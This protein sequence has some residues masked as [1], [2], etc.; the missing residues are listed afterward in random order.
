MIKTLS[1]KNKAL[2]VFN[3]K[4]PVVFPEKGE[5]MAVGDSEDAFDIANVLAYI[6][7][8]DYPVITKE[9]NYKYCAK[10]P[11]GSILQNEYLD[12]LSLQRGQIHIITDTSFQNILESLC[13]IALDAAKSDSKV[14]FISSKTKV[15]TLYERLKNMADFPLDKKPIYLR[16]GW[17]NMC[18]TAEIRNAIKLVEEAKE[19]P[20]ID[21]LVIDAL[22]ATISPYMIK[23]ES[24]LGLQNIA[25][26]KNIAVITSETIK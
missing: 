2:P 3:P 21:V 12:S 18:M 15:E 20:H 17:T 9:S 11:E 4:E 25:R 8:R 14:F 23:K 24:L 1:Y 6:P 10:L 19:H 13:K 22:E 16:N 26:E 5:Q 7:N